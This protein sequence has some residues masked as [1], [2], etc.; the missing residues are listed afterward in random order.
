MVTS[1]KTPK[2]NR[3]LAMPAFLAEEVADYIRLFGIQDGESVSC[4]KELSLSG[5]G[6]RLPSI[7]RAAYSR[8]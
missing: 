7:G 6:A 3:I 1:P 5:D 8:A 4:R 2:S